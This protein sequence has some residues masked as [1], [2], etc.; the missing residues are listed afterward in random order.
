MKEKSLKKK[1]NLKYS[2]IC[3]D[4]RREI[5]NKISLMGI[6]NE[7]ITIPTV[8][9]MF[10]KLSFH[11]VFDKFEQG[12]NVTIKILSPENEELFK[13]GPNKVDLPRQIDEPKCMMDLSIINLNLKK[14]GPYRLLCIFDEDEDLKH[15]LVFNI[16]VKEST[17]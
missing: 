2:I 11:L 12:G 16:K 6:Y 1:Y 5:G 4:I 10:P 9:F 8:P 15:E 7:N 3:D 17:K 14:E 13:I